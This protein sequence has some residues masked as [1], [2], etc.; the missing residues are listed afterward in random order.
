M[1]IRRLGIFS[2]RLIRA[3]KFKLLF[4]GT[5]CFQMPSTIC[6]GERTLAVAFPPE[7][8]QKNDFINIML[9]DEYGVLRLPH[10]IKTVLDVGAN[11]GLFSLKAANHLHG[12]TVHAYEPNPRIFPY[13]AN[14]LA[15]V[16]VRCFQAGIGSRAGFAFMEDSGDSRL[17]QTRLS[18]SGQIRI[19]S[20]AEAVAEIGGELDLLKLDCEGAEWDIFQDV[21]TFRKIRLIRM[22][23]HIDKQH[24]LDGLR[25]T[26]QSLGYRIDKLVPNQG[27][28]VAWLSR[29]R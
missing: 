20:L 28:G 1:L 21:S 18:D 3:R 12:A 17:A 6:F 26:A 19:V 10:G 23:Y 16:G 9:D 15:Q 14:N 29:L 25:A 7:P 11:S 2:R 4:K 5:R 22:E 27:F 8:T 13:A 24:G